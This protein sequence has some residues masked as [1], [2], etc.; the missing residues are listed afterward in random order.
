MNIGWARTAIERAWLEE[1]AQDRLLRAALVPAA[2]AYGAAVA[3]RNRLY[4]LGW[5]RVT[6]VPATVIAVGNLT[7]GG[8]GKTPTALWL[9]EAL[10]ARGRRVAIV[11][12]G[13]GK[14]RRGV[15]IVSGGD[16]PLV[17]AAD[18]GD[19]AVMLARRFAGPIV[20]GERRVDAARVAI[21]RFGVDTI[22]LDDGVQHRALARD[23]DLILLPNTPVPHRLIPAGP[24]REPLAAIA[25]ARAVLVVGRD[26]AWPAPLAHPAGVP[27]FRGRL[28]AE[29]LVR[30]VGDRWIPIAMEVLRGRAA[31]V[32][33]GVARPERFA[34]L[35]A[36]NGIRPE[37][38][39]VFPDHH[40]YGSVERSTIA[41]A[42]GPVV[43]TE[44]DLVKLADGPLRPDLYALRVALEVEDGPA[45]LACLGLA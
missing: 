33:S 13:Y 14:R 34:A 39:L 3:V 31:T 24:W 7:V 16:G 26:G 42:P 27:V 19:E 41:T 22:V 4:D 20:T 17:T 1:R 5:L 6:R 12:R 40:V 21:D 23:A 18:G 35:L 43:T 10:V 36:A 15:V 37:R 9:A 8:T 25:R 29:A 44:K 30:P 28:V 2:V 32:V 11:A 38:V 45:L